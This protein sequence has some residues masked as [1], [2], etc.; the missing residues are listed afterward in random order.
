MP[1]EPVNFRPPAHDAIDTVRDEGPL[2]PLQ[3]TLAQHVTQ[4]HVCIGVLRLKC[5]Q[6]LE[7]CLPRGW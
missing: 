4:H 2:T 7:R 3:G 6:Y 1:K 5:V